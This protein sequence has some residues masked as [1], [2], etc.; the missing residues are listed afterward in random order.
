MEFPSP[1]PSSGII[2][3][4]FFENSRIQLGSKVPVTRLG[5]KTLKANFPSKLFLRCILSLG[6]FFFNSTELKI[7][8]CH[9]ESNPVP[10][11]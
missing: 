11:A 2:T 10:L 6:G 7:F 4:A 5:P 9:Q 1:L 8:C 3:L